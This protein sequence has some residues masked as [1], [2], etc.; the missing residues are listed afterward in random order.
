M[1][2]VLDGFDAD[3]GLIASIDEFRVYDDA[4]S[5]DEISAVK[6]AGPDKVATPASTPKPTTQP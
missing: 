2:F 5:A 4:L 3:P 1:T 6:D